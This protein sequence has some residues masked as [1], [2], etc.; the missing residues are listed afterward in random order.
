MGLL[1]HRNVSLLDVLIAKCLLEVIGIMAAFFVAWTPLTVL[2]VLDPM[3]DPLLFAGGY[4]LQAWFGSAFGLC[5]A[6]LSEMYEA[7]E[8]ILPPILLHYAAIHRRLQ[9]RGVA[10]VSNGAPPR[11]GRLW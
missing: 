8:Q 1:F 11:N 4:L 5:V 9:S 2:G 10:A 3:P 7:T 6:A